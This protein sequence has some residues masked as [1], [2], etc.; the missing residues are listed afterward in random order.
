MANT[1]LLK[2][3]STASK[4]PL[5]TDLAYGELALNYTD[6][7]IYFKNAS[8]VI[9]SFTIDDNVVTL[10]GTQTLTN[11]TLTSPTISGGTIN[12]AVIGGTTPAAITGSLVT[13]TGNLVSSN[14]SGDEGGEILLAKPQTNTTIAGTGVTIDIWQNRLRFF[15]QG[16][17]A[18]GY[19]I[20]ITGGGAGVGTNLVGGGGGG[21]GTVTSVSGT[22]T[23][24]GLTLTGTVTTSGSLTLGGTLA[25]T[26]SNFSSQTAKT[27]LAAPNAADGTPTFR[28]IVASDVPTL[29][30]NT[31][32]SAATLTTARTISGVSFD[33]SANITLNTSGITENTNLY[34]TNARARSALS[35]TPGSGAYN[36][37]TGVFTIPTDTNQLTN[38]A[39][40]TANL[41]TVTSVAELTI[42]TSGTDITSSVAT[43]TTTPVITLS[44]PT[45]S[46]TNRGALSSADW[47]TFNNKLSSA[48]TS[49]TAGTGLSGG[50]ITSTGTVALANTTVTAGTY[51]NATLTVD[52]QG[53][54]TAAS[55]GTSVSSWSKKTANYTAV[56]GDKIIGDTTA[57]TFTITLPASPTTGNSIVVAD[58]ANWSTTNLTIA[59]NGSTIEGLA[60]NLTLNIPNIEVEF[61]YDGTTWEVFA[62]TGPSGVDVTDDTTTNA[63]V[64]P[65]WVTTTSGNQNVKA[66]SSKLYFNPST[67]TL[68]STDFNSLSDVNRKKDIATIESAVEIVNQ[69][70]GVTFKWKENNQDAIGVIAQEVEQILPQVVATSDTGE[71]SVS[72]GNIIAVLIEAVKEQQKEI[73]EL[74][75]WLR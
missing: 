15:E 25:V 7:K 32:G 8:N 60:E 5:V 73:E 28:A 18:R 55:S 30:Q 69:L 16:G 46:A 19:Y 35:M 23:V 3:S 42:G 70:R 6:G 14:S 63:T 21:S 72:Y 71:K 48:V 34:Y 41:G 4:V 39:G 52:A 13:S 10:A 44:I 59:R 54:L 49:I 27:F 47:T 22:G 29:N 9:K 45:A 11:K 12:N 36:S 64:Y 68:N 58:G 67:G 2:K 1:L 31:T 43:A 26:A 62:F 20:D 74:K 24:S 53:R 66:S 38:T 40:F 57:G 33:G 37:T 50:T 61:I 56:S 17:S 75:K 65:S 51:T